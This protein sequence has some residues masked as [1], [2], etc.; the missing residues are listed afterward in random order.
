MVKSTERSRSV[1][2]G[3][4]PLMPALNSAWSPLAGEE[5][6]VC[7]GLHL[8][9]ILPDAPPSD[10]WEHLAAALL[11][12]KCLETPIVPSPLPGRNQVYLSHEVGKRRL[13]GCTTETVTLDLVPFWAPSLFIQFLHHLRSWNLGM[14]GDGKASLLSTQSLV[15]SQTRC[16]CPQ[17]TLMGT[18]C[19]GNT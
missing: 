7:W 12:T 16:S 17:N 14:E 5:T 1:I 9:S 15:E 3:P 8:W 2:A 10:L 11:V 19:Q 6:S 18:I 13:T 4:C